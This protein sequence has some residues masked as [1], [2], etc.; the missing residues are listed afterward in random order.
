[1][2]LDAIALVVF[3]LFATAGAIRGTLATA[4][5]LVSLIGAYWLSLVL[6]PSL[7]AP[8]AESLSLPS[9]LGT[10]LA[11]LLVFI[12][13]FSI[14]GAGA[15]ALQIVE[16]RHRGDHPRTPIDRLGGGA[17]GV[18]RGGLIVVMVG[19]LALWVDGLRAAGATQALP[20]TGNSAVAKLTSGL[21][22]SGGRLL[23]GT[24]SAEGRVATAMLARPGATITRLRGLLDNPRMLELQRDEFFW[25]LVA[26]RSVASALNRASFLS[27]AYDDTLRHEFADIGMI[28]ASAATDPRLFRNA[29]EEVLEEIAP[30]V[31]GLMND[32]D[33]H[34]LLEDPE[35]RRAL[36]EGDT[37]T[38]LQNEGFQ[39]LV[40]R[41]TAGAD[42]GE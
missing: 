37:L 39:R 2:W 13:A 16:R 30:R 3:L 10:A 22:E 6:A 27:I 5:K 34:A 28:S 21:V 31:E 26:N 11:G 8:L 24:D 23:L 9:L 32:P 1:M 25:T 7:G 15:W 40:S 18:V 17:L 14:L 12:A 41:V 4:G 38:L 29:I 20:S 35:V 33:V 19:W 42:A 36:E